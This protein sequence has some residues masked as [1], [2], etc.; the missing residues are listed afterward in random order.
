MDS[1]QV[2]IASLQSEDPEVLREAAFRAGEENCLQAIPQLSQ[3]LL[4]SSIGVQE[5]AE[6]T[7]RKLGGKQTIE[8][9]VPLL[10]SEAPPVR[11][12]TM[13]ILRDICSQDIDVIAELMRN[14]DS[15][16]RIFAADILGYA[17]SIMAVRPLCEALLRDPEINVRYQ[18][19]VSLGQLGHH[20]AAKCLNQS[21]GDEEWVQFASIEALKK[22]K[23]I[24][25]VD[26]LLQV[27]SKASDLVSVVIIETLGEMAHIKAVPRLLEKIEAS[28]R[29]LQ[30]KIVQALV[31]I[32]GNNAFSLLDAAERERLY[33]ALLGALE[34]EDPDVQDAAVRGL[35]IF[36][37]KEAWIS[38]FQLLVQVDEAREPERFETMIGTLQDLG[39]VRELQETAFSSDAATSSLAIRILTG[40]DSFASREILRTVFW[41]RERDEQR[42]IT[43]SLS[44]VPDASSSDFFLHVLNAHQDGTIIK[45]GLHFLGLTMGDAEASDTVL[46]FLEHPFD[47]VKE[48][49]LE[50][51]IALDTEVVRQRFRSMLDSE[52][53][54]L[55]FMAVYGLGQLQDHES[56]PGVRR[57]LHDE[58]SDVRKVALEA[59]FP[60]AG[61]QED[62]LMDMLE[63]LNDESPEVRKALVGILQ[64][65]A[66]PVAEEKLRQAMTDS[67]EWV[68]IRALESL[69]QRSNL[70]DQDVGFLM[71]LFAKAKTIL[72]LKIIDI[73]GQLGGEA[74][75]KALFEVLETENWEVQ[76]A[77]DRAL[78]QIKTA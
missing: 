43:R 21:L 72:K 52:D 62:V 11:N 68:C 56:M 49:S 51:C 70:T 12:V 8:A 17:N 16:I 28:S 15:D 64:Q 48:K 1:C 29:P 30:N 77:A 59:L 47:D 73:L 40:I 76:E 66:L 3:L 31:S 67:D 61:E 35:N 18:A 46:G 71:E 7:L 42:A 39:M 45:N 14:S 36:G 20:E 6:L 53:P 10:W 57:A 19:A 5:A 27:L 75:F 2:V 78:A 9:L 26:A 54:V 13:D 33:P 23:D 34:D 37:R 38:I 74:S 44:H 69:M 55:R 32:L 50:A 22:I 25:S 58:A 24:S 60:L 4:S 41:D 65:S 63:A